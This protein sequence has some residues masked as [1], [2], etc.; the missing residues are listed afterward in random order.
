MILDLEKFIQKEEPYWHELEGFLQRLEKQRSHLDLAEIK[1]FHYLY[2]RAAAALS[3]LMTFSAEQEIKGYLERLVARTYGEIHGGRQERLKFSPF[4]WFFKTFPPTFRRHIRSFW[5]AVLITILGISFGV[6]LLS[7]EPQAK[8]TLL[9]FAHLQGSPS[10]RVAKEQEIK[11]ENI[12]GRQMRFSSQLMTHNIKTSIF[13]MSLGLTWGIGTLIILFYNGVIIGAV[14]FD[15][16]AD[17]QAVFLAGWLLPH[18][19]IEIPAFLIAGQAGLVLAYALIGRGSRQTLAQRMRQ[20][21]PD[22]VTLI[23]GLGVLLCWAGL[24]EAFFS[25]YHE[26]VVPYSLKIAFGM[27]QLILLLLFLTRSGSRQ[28]E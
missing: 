18:G 25:Q 1:R 7:V 16:I 10:E 13:A 26:P 5:L 2:Q 8:D 11:G 24:I 12:A 27:M 14:A 28:G 3:Q 17:G 15:Y 23:G 22:L 21:T 9:P 19:S 6:F 4:F 20:I